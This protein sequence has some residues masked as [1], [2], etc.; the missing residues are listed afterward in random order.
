MFNRDVKAQTRVD[1]LI[2]R[3]ARI[4]GDVDFEGGLHLEGHITG[5]VR[6]YGKRE[7]TLSLGEE[8]RIEGE[9]ETTH[10]VLNGVIQGD[11][12]APGRVVLGPRA[13]VL[14]NLHYGVIESASGA[15]I[16]GTLVQ[17]APKGAAAAAGPASPAAA[18]DPASPGTPS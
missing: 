18:A 12:R 5:N 8:A 16:T 9:V 17:V 15:E 4:R 7:S 3:S 6:A 11:I 13:R 10:L 14:G 2:G 1:I